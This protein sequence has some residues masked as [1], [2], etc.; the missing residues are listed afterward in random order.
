MTSEPTKNVDISVPAPTVA[1]LLK[2]G[3]EFD[4][5]LKET[6]STAWEGS[7]HQLHVELASDLQS[8]QLN[9]NKPSFGLPAEDAVLRFCLDTPPGLFFDFWERCPPYCA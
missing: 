4:T 1:D 8:L 2:V 3:G 6:R 9:R 5:R 7:A